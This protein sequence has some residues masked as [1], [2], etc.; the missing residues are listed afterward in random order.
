MTEHPG[1]DRRRT[2]NQARSI[3]QTSRSVDRAVAD[4]D[5]LLAEVDN[6]T[7]SKNPLQPH[8]PQESLVVRFSDVDSP[9]KNP[10]DKDLT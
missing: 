3:G 1:P 4:I 9:L 10:D 5:A 8:K 7:A 2:R 6:D